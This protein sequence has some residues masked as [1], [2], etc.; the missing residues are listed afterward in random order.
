MENNDVGILVVDDET[1]V[2][3]SLCSW[4]EKDGYRV[5]TAADG[6]E[7]LRK[8]SERSW[9]VILVDLKMPNIDGM[10]LQRRIR[11]VDP[12]SVVIIITAYATVETAVEALKQGAFDYVMKPI[13]PDD[14]SRIV[15]NAI[16]HRRLKKENVQLR[17]TIE[18]LT[19]VTDLIGESSQMQEIHRLIDTV[20][21][22]D[23]TV[24]IRGDSGTGKELVARLIHAKSSRRH[25]PIVPLN[26]GAL[27]ESLLESELFGH[28]KGA[29][30]G[31]LYR[32][33]GKLEIANGGTLFLDEIG[34]I[35]QKTQVDLL[36]V[37]ETKQF[38]RLGGNKLISVDFRVICAT[39]QDLEQ[40]VQEG[41][42]REDLY[43]RI[44]VF[45]IR[46]PPLRERRADI[47]ALVEHFVKKFSLQIKKR[48]DGTTPEAM[49]A[50]IA[51][52]WRGN[53]RELENAV[54]RA[55]VVCTKSQIGV[56]DL[57]FRQSTP[58]IDADSL[59]EVERNHIERILLR[60]EWNITKSARMLGIDRVTLYNKIKK[61]HLTRNAS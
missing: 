19:S 39:N 8:L 43:Y 14:L 61:Y 32:H 57:P 48:I 5:D 10:E 30:T 24:L 44:N 6:I 52:E 35:A 59:D 41:R 28:E 55:V 17:H 51:C 27:T 58:P 38:T 56:E 25:L 50:M 29:F 53:V 22:T 1:A 34:T 13:D 46:V 31:A 42:F 3:D 49:E 2:R 11:K 12:D 9:E 4:F 15:R 40:V 45:E 21:Q 23:V 37:L 18:E 16:E 54:E 33:K 7:A 20:S 47:P 26:C 60:T 36:R